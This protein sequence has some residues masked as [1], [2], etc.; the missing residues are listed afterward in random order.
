MLC[1]STEGDTATLSPAASKAA[2]A[3]VLW[4]GDMELAFTNICESVSCSCVLQ[5][6]LPEDIMS[7]V[8]DASGSGLGG[9]LQVRREDRWEAAAFFSRQTRGPEK[10]YSA[11]ELE[12]LAL[13]ETIRHFAYY[14]FRRQFVAFTHHK[15]LCSLLSSYRLNGRLR[16]LGMKLQ[17]CNTYLNRERTFRHSITRRKETW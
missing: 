2:P 3:K 17:T 10:R 14:L 16:R 5:I 15:L 12:E 13:V 1:V 8:T 9:I 4:T 11:T 7:I 6:S